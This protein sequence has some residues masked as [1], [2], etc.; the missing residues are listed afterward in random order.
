M[1]AVVVFKGGF[2][3]LRGVELAEIP[4][5]TA[6]VA[7]AVFPRGCLAM[8][9]CDVLGPV[10]ADADFAE[11]F[12]V[13]GRPAVSPARL[14]LV[15]VLQFAEGLTDRQAAHAVRSRLDWKYALSLESTDTGF[16]FSVLSE[17]RARLAEA[18]AGRAVFDAVLRAAGE[19][20][21]VKPGGRRRTDATRVLAP[22]RDLNR[23]EFVVETLRTAL[24][25][26]AE[27]AG[28]WLV[29]VAAPEWFDRYSAR[30]E[31]SRFPSRW[32]ARVEHGDQ[33]GADGMTLLEA[34]CSTQAPPGLWNLPAVELLRRTWVQ[35]FQHVEG[36]VLWRHPKDAPPGLIR[37]R[38]PH[39]PEARTGAKRDLAWSGYKVHLGETCE[40]DAPHLITHIHT[41]PAPVNDNA[42]LEDVHTALAERE[43][44]PDE[45][46]VDAGYIDAE[47][48]HHAR[49]DH[50][51]DLVGPVGQNTNREQMT[52]H[53]FDNTHF[54]VDWN[55]R[56]AVRPGG[57]TSVQWRDAHGNRGTPV[58]RVRFARRHCGPCEL[59]T[60]CTN[61]RTGRNLTL[62]PRAEHD[63][64]QQARVEQDTDH[65]RRRY[66][67]RAGVEGAIS[68]GVQ[69]FG[70][71]R[72]RYRGLA[73]TRLQHH[74]TG[75]AIN[76]ARLDAWHT[77][78]PLA[79]T[80]VSPFA[81]LCPAG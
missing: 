65:W 69:A 23:L 8:R 63:I 67:H 32:A 30:P 20:G 33:C 35:Q 25:Q 77:G 13:R 22:T 46:L 18:D 31:D 62:R 1:Q 59:R 19:A 21:L 52:D 48:I 15:S 10:F 29:T 2:V 64:L 17:F 36:V 11:L 43:L 53:F 14:A 28:D 24:D 49:R 34:A 58:T 38:T 4:E 76:L 80:R 78:R 79:R 37:L 12:A 71:R 72:S 39:E 44:L 7:R 47:Q 54:A 55:R 26:V 40:P 75:A 68:Q 60:S 57:H 70:L 61:A 50:D 66:G 6:R 56:Q 27:V 51:I 5:E 42:V 74:L 45:H 41:T 3:S 73:K 81:A 9:M 16:D